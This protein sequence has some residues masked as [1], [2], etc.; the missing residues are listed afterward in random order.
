MG[1]IGIPIKLL[2][3]AQVYFSSPPPPSPDLTLNVQG[4][5]CTLELTSGQIFRGKL[6][7]GNP[8]FQHCLTRSMAANACVGV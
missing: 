7:E 6:I 5:V 3:E 4:H 1:S 8:P 2:N